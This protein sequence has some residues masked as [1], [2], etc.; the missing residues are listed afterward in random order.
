VP[1][2]DPVL[3]ELYRHRFEGVAEEMGGTLRRTG[4]SPN[5]KERLDF[6][7]A[8]FDAEGGLVAQAAHIPVH[9]GA[10]PASVAAAL[11]SVDR[12]AEGDVVVLND[13]YEGGTHLPDVTMV[14]PVFVEGA[15]AP[16]FFVASRA[17]HADVGG[18]TPGSL[19]LATE[20]VQEGLV[21]PPVKL[22]EQGTPNEALMRLLLRNVRTP[23][24]R[25]GDLAAQRA[26]HAVGARRL[27]ELVA[28]H[29]P[30]EVPAYARH[31]QAYSERRV[32]AALADWPDGTYA[33][34]D[35]LERADGDPA[36]IRVTATVEGDAVTFDFAGTDP[37]DEGNLNAVRPITASACYYVVQ[38]LV[39]G[40]MPVNAGSLA[41]VTVEAPAGTIVNA[42]PPHAVA[43][44]NVETSQRIVDVVLGALAE[45]LPDRVPAAG[46]GT[47][48]NLTIGGARFTDDAVSGER[49]FAY[50]ETIAGGMG[51]G[52]DGDGLGGV[53]VHM[54]NTLNTPV[55]ALEQT[56]PFRVATYRL[57]DGSGG[58]GR[59]RG[60]DGLVRVYELLVPVTVTMLSTRRAEG[61]WGRDGGERGAPGRNVLVH[62]DGTEEALPAHFSR[63]LPAGSRLR[64]ETPGGGGFGASAE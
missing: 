53:H 52:P 60:G 32:R 44:G 46:Q 56:Y 61:P 6:S 38:G 40:E 39:E 27:Q 18:M 37:A 10:M 63:R 22:Y 5:I 24:E 23:E 45:A 17:H 20:L 59:H 31:L 26:A 21:I 34:A 16:A 1:D 8:V 7:C 41:P 3:L 12:W 30:D 48:N 58:A 64:V 36:T 49:S 55:E 9:L 15:D 42:D 11:D 50:Y 13:P 51:A 25:R 54:T 35:T 57:R 29:G 4:Y 33:F 43:G 62:P 14:S 2:A 47:M 28:A 19:P